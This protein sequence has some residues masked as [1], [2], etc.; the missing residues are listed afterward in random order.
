M[1]GTKKSSSHGG[2]REGAGK[3]AEDKA[4]GLQRYQ[5][6]LDPKT[7]DKARKI[8]DGNLSLGLRL[9]AKGKA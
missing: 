1:P 7:V 5:V 4:S 2:A 9:L 3:P 8:G 6:L